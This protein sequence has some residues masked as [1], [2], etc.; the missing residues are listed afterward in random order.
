MASGNRFGLP[1]NSELHYPQAYAP[2]AAGFWEGLNPRQ[3][4]EL[5]R[6][7]AIAQEKVGYERGTP[8]F[9]IQ[10]FD[11][12]ADPAEDAGPNIAARV[13]DPHSGREIITNTAGAAPSRRVGEDVEDALPRLSIGGG[14]VGAGLAATLLALAQ[15]IVPAAHGAAMALGLTACSAGVALCMSVRR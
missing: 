1:S 6:L 15:L 11:P 14:L 3:R 13:F 5:E 4:T 8:K 10:D 2:V 12:G 9:F 7:Q